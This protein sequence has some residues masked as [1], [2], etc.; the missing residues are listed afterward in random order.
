MVKID[1]KLHLL[2]EISRGDK[3]PIFV[4]SAALPTEIF[5]SYFDLFGPTMN[6]LVADGYG[7]FAPRYAS[8]VLK[9][10]A[11]RAIPPVLEKGSEGYE[12]AKAEVDARLAGLYNE[13]HR[14]TFVLALKDRK[15]D[16]VPIDEAKAIGAISEDEYARA[17]AAVIFFTCAAQSVPLE[18]V[19]AA[20][21]GLTLFNALITASSCTEY[22]A[23]LPM[24]MTGGSSGAKVD[25]SPTP[26]LGSPPTP[27]SPPTSAA[28][29]KANSPGAAR[30]PTGIVISSP[31]QQ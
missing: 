11:M 7:H 21:G 8:L 27:A 5:E 25:S 12:R 9:Q 16:T 1:R 15:W 13:L 20:L 29:M 6:R 23:S 31:G 3:P 26:S 18:A 30:R 2:I 17:D 4:H 24:L 19:E 14:L 28:S 10:T 22:A